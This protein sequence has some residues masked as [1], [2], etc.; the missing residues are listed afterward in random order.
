LLFVSILSSLLFALEG[1]FLKKGVNKIGKNNIPEK[2]LSH[3]KWNLTSVIIN[4][5]EIAFGI[6]WATHGFNIRV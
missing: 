5:T 1:V 2:T 4:F 6:F 3:N